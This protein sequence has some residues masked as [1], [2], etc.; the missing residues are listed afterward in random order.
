[1]A[2]RSNGF[3]TLYRRN[4]AGP[5]IVRWFDHAGRRVQRS[6]RT[7]D[8]RAAERIAA[9]LT[10][11]AALRREG[12][13][14][15]M[16]DGFA[17]ADR[18]PLAE[19]VAAYLAHCAA[20][21][22]A[23]AAIAEKRRHLARL[24]DSTGAGR[25]SDLTADALERHL[26]GLREA[27]LSARTWNFAR[28]IA[29]A[30][31]NW[32]VRTGRAK[33]NALAVAPRLDEDRD[34][35]RVRRALDDDELAR[36]LAVAEEH[37]RKCWY[38]LAA[39]AGLRRGDLK[40]LRWGAVDLAVG[41]ITISD[42]KAKR[43]DVVPLHP[44]LAEALAELAAE[45]PALPTAKVFATAV[46]SV[47]VAKDLLRAGIARREPV[48]DAAGEPVMIGTGKRAHARTRITTEDAQG[49]VVDLHALRTT[50][51]TNLA[52]A[53]VAPQLAQRVLR[54]A[55]YR[56]TAKHYT[57]LGVQDVRRAVEALPTITQPA[58][59]RA[60][61][62]LDGAETGQPARPQ[63]RPQLA[64]QTARTGATGR[65][66]QAA[67]L[68]WAGERNG[69]PCA[70]LRD[71]AHCGAAECGEAGGGTRTR[72]VQLGRLEL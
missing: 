27:G 14:D 30:F 48:L 34:R 28:Q 51:G 57:V 36:L 11:D 33:R 16:E 24:L 45:R 71:V 64:R 2:K 29:V 50:L 63:Q 31:A 32:T 52:R 4:P 46:T 72:N 61:G 3:G 9:K 43:T 20:A 54:H 65:D 37:G 25:L 58:A 10:G 35:R 17:Q 49:R 69:L 66:G 7:T 13:V 6:T 1:M 42:G 12:V 19:H 15:A 68:P 21:G 56:T 55:D 47:T 39:L 44:Q 60:T 26:R 8:K 5:W 18:V 23:P 38:M 70:N 59:L 41:T 62:T 53:G 67:G 40:R 22:H